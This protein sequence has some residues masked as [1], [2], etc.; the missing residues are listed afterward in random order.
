[1]CGRIA[2]ITELSVLK[3]EFEIYEDASDFTP[4]WNI[5]PGQY[6]P[7]LVNSQG[8]NRLESFLWGFIPSWAK[9]PGRQGSINARA[10]TV[11]IRPSFRDAFRKRRCLIPVDGF[12]EW[13]KNNGKKIPLYFSMKSG[14]PFGLA[15]IFETWTAQNHRTPLI[16]CAIITTEPNE[17]IKPIHNRMPAI[18]PRQFIN[19]WLGSGNDSSVL[20][21]IL[22]PYPSE[23]MELRVGIGP[24]F[25]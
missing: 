6:I 1:M 14:L 9:D 24:D 2:L 11:S 19:K 15:G 18:V 13:Q 12:Y 20:L 21:S 4:G 7:A 10:E 16:T 23:E 5:N 8:R 25:A 22:R 17:L 3:K